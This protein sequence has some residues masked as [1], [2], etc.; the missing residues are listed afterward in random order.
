MSRQVAESCAAGALKLAAEKRAAVSQ[1]RTFLG[2]F[3]SMGRP[4]DLRRDDNAITTKR[5]Q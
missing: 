1:Y 2:V 5:V 3:E 4:A